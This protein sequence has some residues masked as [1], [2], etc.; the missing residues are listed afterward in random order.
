VT[1]RTPPRILLTGATGAFGRFVGRALLE[2]GC[3]L[4]CL[5]RGRGGDVARRVLAALDPDCARARVVVLEGDILLPG[6]GLDP[7]LVR[8]LEGTVDGIVHSAATTSFGMEVELARRVN[9][10]GTHNVLDFARRARHLR[11]LGYVSTAFVAGKRTGVIREN[12]LDH[13]ADFVTSYERSKYEAE[14]L[15]RRSAASLP[16]AVFRPSVIVGDDADDRPNALRFALSL[17]RD[18]VLP[19]LPAAATAPIDLIDATDAADALARLTLD[20]RCTGTYHLTAGSAAPSLAQLMRAAGT[21]PIGFVP[22]A[23]FDR[24]LDRLRSENPRGAALYDR[25]DTFI[26]IV[27]YPKVFSN[28][29]T[30]A[31]LR[32]SVVRRDP[33]AA[34]RAMFAEPSRSAA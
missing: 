30:E 7:G 2:H 5:A 27:A 32:R 24:E 12:E 19:L 15:V 34:V 17:L 8:H 4:V 20:G 26:R 13:D 11:K 10:T 22:A 14:L 21:P 3:E 25:I 16:I 9:V 18:R 23:T 29:S 6:L 33:L 31:A 28:G 1:S